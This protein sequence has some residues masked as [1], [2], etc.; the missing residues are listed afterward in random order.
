MTPSAGEALYLAGLAFAE[1]LRFW[2]RVERLRPSSAWQGA[3][4]T[5]W[6]PERI[7]LGGVLLGIW[8]LPLVSIF[9][10]WLSPFDLALPTWAIAVGAALFVASCFLRWRAQADLGRQWSFTL[11]TAERQMLVTRGIYARLR[12]PIYASLVPWALAQGLLLQNAVAGVGGIVAVALIWLVRVPREEAM[13]IEHFGDAY[14][15]YMSR[16][17]RLLPKRLARDRTSEAR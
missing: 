11:E 10:R 17:G 15:E 4:R 16:T 12:H 8:V 14:R 2:R 3:R 5:S 1:S 6:L 7:V 13:M 9:T